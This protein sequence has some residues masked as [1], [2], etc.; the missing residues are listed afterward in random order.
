MPNPAR[1]LNNLP[2][3]AFAI[4]DERLRTLQKQ[5]ADIIRLD[6]G[7]PDLPPADF[8][9]EALCKSAQ[10][11]GNHGYAGYSGT[12]TFR[13]AVA[14]YY[15][16]RFGVVLD[17]DREVLPLIG[18]K[19]GL[20]NFSLAYLDA[21]DLAL[22]PDVGYPS[23]RMGATL[24]GADVHLLPLRDEN[25]FLPDLDSIPDQVLRRAKI[26]WINYPNNPTG[27]IADEPFYEKALT[28]CRVNNILLASDNPYCDVTFEGYNAPSPLQI[29]GAKN[30]TIEFISLS[31]TYNMAG[32]RVGAAVGS[33]EAL[34]HLLTVKSNLDS[35]HFKP[36]YD[37]AISALDQTDDAWLR[38]RN[39][40]YQERRDLIMH[41][42][43]HI[44]LEA[45][46]PLG[47]LY[48]WAKVLRGN[49]Q[50][51]V[52][53]ALED[54]H[55]SIAPGTVYGE[56]GEGYVRL[57]TS[58]STLRILEAIERLKVWYSKYG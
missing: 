36:I 27:A 22:V 9:V 3:Y 49:A 19:E 17:P 1:R 2:K 11:P 55:V 21:G 40:I 26:L 8:V 42:L 7:N 44:G 46:K 53:S 58:V 6:I 43:P 39:A 28:F 34:S 20:V 47:T 15:H 50:R 51:Y 32:W 54:A 57:S 35:G 37:A 16:R 31:K 5:G 4:I 56:G 33:A 48:I 12:P 52:E 41:A 23:Y 13:Q 25:E 30:Q 45:R 38:S 10:Q 29:E 24:A 18:S 14:R